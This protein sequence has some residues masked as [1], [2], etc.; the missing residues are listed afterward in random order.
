M[1]MD[2]DNLVSFLS[3]YTPSRITA[4]RADGDLLADRHHLDP[5]TLR[6]TVERTVVR[7]GR[8]RTLTFLKRLFG[9]PEMRDWWSGA[10]FGQIE[11]YGEDGAAL[12]AG[13]HRMIVVG[14]R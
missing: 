3:A 8:A 6:F 2:V 9:F 11:G 1:I 10:G 5:L 13:H 12:H 4:H 14:T 7:D